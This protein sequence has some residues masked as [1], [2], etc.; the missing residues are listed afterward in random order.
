[1]TETMEQKL[2]PLRLGLAVIIVGLIITGVVFG[3]N[4]NPIQSIA[5]NPDLLAKTA[6]SSTSL[7]EAVT[8]SAGVTLPV[9]WG[10]LGAKLVEAGV[11]DADKFK[12]LYQ[13]RGTW[14]EEEQKL[15][16]NTANGQIKITRE[17]ADYWLN[18][19]WA[20]GL[21]NSNPILDSG[22]MTDPR[23]GGAGGFASTGGWSMA[24]GQ[25]MD[26]YGRHQLV[27]LTATQ[28]ALVDKI[29]RGIYRP[30]CG[31]STHFPDCNHGMAMLGLLELMASQGA[32]ELQMWQT[33]LVVNS[34]WFPATYL[35]IAQ[36]FKDQ[37]IAWVEV[38]PKT[39]LGE[40]YS[41]NA[42][43]AKIQA[44]VSKSQNGG[45]GSSCSV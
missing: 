35:S 18:L 5:T 21:A 45:S 17:N 44:L 31:N 27:K 23:Y 15:L 30:C 41:S 8:P 2:T 16:L 7:D 42:G 20:L 14:T 22:E 28:Q 11:I 36:Y 12:A 40:T 39:V 26:H 1:M 6:N 19:L 33:A 13:Q 34:Y 38:D 32:S 4:P 25:P 10:D 43:S 9:T 3:K 29:S 37:G 24:K